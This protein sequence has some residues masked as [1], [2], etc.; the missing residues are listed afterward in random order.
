MIKKF[1][2]TNEKEYDQVII[3]VYVLLC[4]I[5]L[6][7]GLNITAATE[8]SLDSFFRHLFWVILSFAFTFLFVLRLNLI[9]FRKI[10][11]ALTLICII[12]ISLVLIWGTESKGAQRSFNIRGIGFQPSDLMRVAL[13]F[14]FAHFLDKKKELI[15]ESTFTNFFK[16][17]YPLVVITI[18]S[19]AVIFKQK[20]FSTI[21]ISAATLY[22]LL[23]LAKI[24]ITTLLSFLLIGVVLFVGVIMF[25]SEYRMRRFETY[26]KYSLFLK[27]FDK[28]VENIS[29]DD[30]QARGSLT[31]LSQGKFIGTSSVYGQAK[32][33][34]L[35]ESKTDYIFS[36]IGEE[37]GLFGSLIV[38]ALFVVLFFRGLYRSFEQ[39][40]L[41]LK[42]LGIGLTLNI[43]FNAF[44]NI[45]VAMSA[46][47]S[48]GVTLP[49]VSHGGT[50]MLINTIS[51]GMLLNITAKKGL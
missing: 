36:V 42:L 37:H 20:H 24:R 5:G 46:L 25:G 21:V 13:I 1:L 18:I 10:I 45:G 51:I 4:I 33:K 35:P 49:F 16:L 2:R 12:L 19:F 34:Y 17:F 30:F 8:S 31:S 38:F 39:D 7:M 23:W 47:P 41:Y 32:N 44:V 6:Y 9:N 22:S 15:P 27:L 26:Y 43:F 3:I 40:K 28:T 29:T 14:Y 48:T 50:S 11:P